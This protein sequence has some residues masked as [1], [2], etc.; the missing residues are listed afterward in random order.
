M[1][2]DYDSKTHPFKKMYSGNLYPQKN[3]GYLWINSLDVDNIGIST[4]D[5]VWIT[6][7]FL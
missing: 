1:I 2:G 3:V 4:S 6:P 7:S 5:L